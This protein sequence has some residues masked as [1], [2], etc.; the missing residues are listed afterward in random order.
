MEIS[1]HL[2]NIE[3]QISLSC[4]ILG[5]FANEIRRENEHVFH[6]EKDY[7][8]TQHVGVAWLCLLS[9]IIVFH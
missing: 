9:Q 5:H 2:R 3:D 4:L 8:N 6:C 7:E 1:F